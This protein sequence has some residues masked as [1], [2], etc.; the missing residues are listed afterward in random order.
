MSVTAAMDALKAAI[1]SVDKLRGYRGDQQGQIQLPAGVV[2]L[3]ALSW[4]TYCSDPAEARFTIAL[5]VPLDDRAMTALMGFIGPLVLAI[6]GAG[7]S[8]DPDSEAVPISH[9]FGDGMTAAGY[10]IPVF[11]P[12]NT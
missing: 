7:G 8:V 2:S 6:E 12:L 5:L 4:R 9:D 3:P 11:F 10:E 1:N